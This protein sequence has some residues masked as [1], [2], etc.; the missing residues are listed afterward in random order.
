MAGLQLGLI[1]YGMGNLGSV[2][3]ACAYLELP[4]QRVAQGREFSRCDGLILPGVGAFGDCMRQL[5]AHDCVAALC[6]WVREDRPLLGICLGL[7]VLFAGSD[8]SPGVPGL[9]LFAGRVCR[10][11]QTP[12][13]KVPQIGWNQVAIQKPDC[14]LFSG[15][16]DASYFYFVHSYH[17]VPEAEALQEVAGLTGYG[18]DYA[19]VLWRNALV[20]VQFHP[21]RSHRAGLRMMRNFG[22][23]VAEWKETRT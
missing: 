12:G 8:E 1:D 20:A 9:G 2:S 15:I 3:N 10:F 19:S 5:A 14:P 4:V 7:Q 13:L 23:M 6:D 17:V 22:R 16:P 11:A 18:L 21:E